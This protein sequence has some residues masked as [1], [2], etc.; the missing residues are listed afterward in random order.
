MERC[1]SLT[2]IFCGGGELTLALVHSVRQRL[3]GVRLHNVYGPT[4]A[5]VDSTAWTLQA[6]Q[7]LPTQAPPIGRPISNTRLY[8][9]DAHDRPV[10]LGAVG[11]L[12][13]GGVGVARGYL[14]LP[15]LQAER[16]IVS[17]F[18][19]GDRLYRTGDLVRYRAD[20]ELDFVGRNDFQVKLRGLRVE[21]GEI[22]ALLAAYPA[23]GQAVVLMREE[24]LV[25]YFTCND[26]QPAPALEALRSHLL[27]RMPEY[28]VPQAFVRLAALP[29]SRNGKVDRSALP[30][31]DAEAVISRAYQAPQGELETALAAIWTE[32]LKIEQVGRDDN[33]FELGGHSLLAVSLVARMRQAGL[34]VDARTL[35]SQP[36]LAGLAASTQ[37][38]QLAVVVPQTTIPGLGK[39]RRL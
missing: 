15:H 33:F 30:A 34:H 23:V 11:Q 21:L 20:G 26:G 3:P 38:E 10:P 25:A 14:G 36:T 22:E 2:D 8:V 28:M 5:T 17:P 1:T 31:P 6:Q 9:L 12:H 32:V 39:R 29:L 35:F 7:P 13:I 4:E 19:E 24:R 27:A 18:V 16:F 37:R